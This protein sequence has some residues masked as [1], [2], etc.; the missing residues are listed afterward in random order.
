MATLVCPICGNKV[1]VASKEEAPYRPFCSARCKQV[2]LGRW[3]S[4]AYV[5]RERLPGDLSPELKPDETA[6][7]PDA[8]PPV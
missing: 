3:L 8:D 6:A 4:E 5:I 1:T 7:E 2:D